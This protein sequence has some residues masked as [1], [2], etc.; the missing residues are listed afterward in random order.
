L[1][2]SDPFYDSWR[3]LNC[4]SLK[5]PT[6]TIT[7]QQYEEYGQQYLIEHAEKKQRNI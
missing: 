1:F 7:K 2:F 5:N 6:P 3:G 4:I